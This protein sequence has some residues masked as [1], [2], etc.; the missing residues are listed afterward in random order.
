VDGDRSQ[1]PAL[2]VP[3][4]CKSS[5]DWVRF[6]TQPVIQAKNAGMGQQSNKVI[7]RRRRIRYVKRKKDAE[8]L[9]PGKAASAS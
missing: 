6:L 5:K 3:A 7:K 9:K 8:K 4:K 2:I 1:P